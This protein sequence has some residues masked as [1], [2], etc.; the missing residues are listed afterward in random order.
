[1]ISSDLLWLG[2]GLGAVY[3]ISYALS[4]SKKFS[5][6]LGL[7][8]EGPIIVVRG[9]SFTSRLEKFGRGHA[10][11]FRLI[12]DISI[13]G[14][15][16]VGALGFAFL[17]FNLLQF[18]QKSPSASPVIPLVP[19]WTIGLDALP[20]FTLAVL[21]A[22][23]PH[24][25]M[26]AL[27]AAAEGVPV[28][29]AGAF[30]AVL[31]PGG[32]AELDE[33]E[34]AKRP[35]RSQARVY[36]AGSFANMIVFLLVLVLAQVLVQP[37]GVRVTGT[38]AGYPASGVLQ[39]EDVIVGVNGKPV[40][41]MDDFS[42]ALSSYKPGDSVVLTVARGGRVINVSV[43]LSARPGEPEKPMLGVYISQAISS[44]HLYSTLW[45][46]AVV[47][48]SVALLNMLPLY[49]LDGGRLLALAVSSF[50]TRWKK[51]RGVTTV[52]SAY[53]ALLLLLNVVLSLAPS[54]IP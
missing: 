19:G 26:H 9:S 1:M 30:L 28:K 8:L 15:V 54:M 34:L 3:G 48:G 51:A 32:F 47:S 33:N 22:L 49:P 29:S 7:S 17:H 41:T 2:V 39:A 16:V 6:R 18:L 31:F 20:F 12:G 43:V 45:W 21:A 14:G 44:E 5:A 4:R 10:R 37:L 11:I 40:R 53:A 42:S 23:L 27:V 38:M 36:A 46:T 13:V 25:L 52:I 35:P 50:A 24:E